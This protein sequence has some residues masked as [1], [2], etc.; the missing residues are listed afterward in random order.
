[1]AVDGP[2]ALRPEELDFLLLFIVLKNILLFGFVVRTFSDH[3]CDTLSKLQSLN[4]PQVIARGM[5]QAAG[6]PRLAPVLLFSLQLL[7]M[8]GSAQAKMANN[9]AMHMPASL[10]GRQAPPTSSCGPPTSG[11]DGW[12]PSQGY[13]RVDGASAS[14]ESVYVAWNRNLAMTR[15]GL[16]VITPNVTLAVPFS[17]LPLNV[18]WTVCVFALCPWRLSSTSGW[19]ASVAAFALGGLLGHLRPACSTAGEAGKDPPEP[20]PPLFEFHSYW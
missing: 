19:A 11:V 13:L 17:Q 2:S 15:C 12:H 1:M 3:I 14:S 18:L 5:R 4:T 9:T 10:H 20:H 7:L 8:E 16:K 6:R